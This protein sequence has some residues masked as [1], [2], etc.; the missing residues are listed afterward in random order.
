MELGEE[1]AHLEVL[2]NTENG[3]MVV[4]CIDG[5]CERPLRTTQKQLNLKVD[6]E[7]FVLQAVANPLTGETVGDSSEFEG[8][9]PALKS[10]A[11]WEGKFAEITLQGQVYKNLDFDYPPSE[12]HQHSH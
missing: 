3:K 12:E 6:G 11:K 5:E 8:E 1:A 2:W 4:Y 9:F 10:R 7:T